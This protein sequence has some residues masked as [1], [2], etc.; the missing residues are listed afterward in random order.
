MDTRTQLR[1]LARAVAASLGYAYAP[2]AHD[3]TDTYPTVRMTA[4]DGLELTVRMEKGR[5]VFGVGNALDR[6]ASSHG[7]EW[8]TVSVGADRAP[9]AIAREVLRRLVPAAREHAAEVERRNA[10]C[11]AWKASNLE[12]ARALAAL[13][14]DWRRRDTEGEQ[15]LYGAHGL[16]LR[17]GGSSVRFEYFS[18]PRELALEIVRLV[19]AHAAQGAAEVAK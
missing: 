11:H 16:H 13:G 10:S 19:Q 12:T 15:A 9:E 2:L 1:T 3:T 6:D 17:T 8:P 18:V 7:L 5:A 14:L 4:P